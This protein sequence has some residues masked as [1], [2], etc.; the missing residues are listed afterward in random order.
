MRRRADVR[1][2]SAACTLTG[3]QAANSKDISHWLLYKHIIM[4]NSNVI[5]LLLRHRSRRSRPPSSFS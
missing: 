4:L 3:R 1:N 5:C 2:I